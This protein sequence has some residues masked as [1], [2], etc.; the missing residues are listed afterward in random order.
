MKDLEEVKISCLGRSIGQY[1]EPFLLNQ[2]LTVVKILSSS[3]YQMLKPCIT[4]TLV[5]KQPSI[6]QGLRSN[7]G[8]ITC[9]SKWHDAL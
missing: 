2:S 3:C 6:A 4:M 5:R 1:D 8:I 7:G 9:G